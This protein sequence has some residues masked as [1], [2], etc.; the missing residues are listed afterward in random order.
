VYVEDMVHR[1]PGD[2]STLS[3]MER[4]FGVAR[5]WLDAEATGEDAGERR[6]AAFAAPRCRCGA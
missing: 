4:P 2:S 6:R 5:T 3:E 1:Q